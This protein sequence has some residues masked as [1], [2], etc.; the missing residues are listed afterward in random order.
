MTRGVD[1]QGNKREWRFRK[2]KEWKVN[3]GSREKLE[4]RNSS[5]FFQLIS[6]AVILLAL[7]FPEYIE[8]IDCEAGWL[9]IVFF[10]LSKSLIFIVSVLVV[11]CIPVSLFLWFSAGLSVLLILPFF[12]FLL[13]RY[14]SLK[15]QNLW[16]VWVIFPMLCRPQNNSQNKLILSHLPI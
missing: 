11:V 16:Q 3:R 7:I 9:L 15:S 2:N 4:K 6:P 14:P 10:L 12:R 13:S 5:F 1:M 8:H